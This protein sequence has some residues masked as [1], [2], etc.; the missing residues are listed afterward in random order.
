[1]EAKGGDAA[2]LLVGQ[3]LEVQQRAAAAR[4]AGQDLLPAGLVLVAVRELD[5]GVLERE[6]L[7]FGQFFEA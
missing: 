4:E 5:V 1:M 7:V 2:A 6:V 3:E